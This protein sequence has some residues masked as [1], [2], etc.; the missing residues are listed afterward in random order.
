MILF[1][2]NINFTY[3]SNFK[4]FIL[5]LRALVWDFVILQK[6]QREVRNFLVWWAFNIPVLIYK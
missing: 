5:Y 1:I 3:M 4:F 2:A 6:T